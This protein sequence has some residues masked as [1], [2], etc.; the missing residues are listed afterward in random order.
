M[1]SQSGLCEFRVVVCLNALDPHLP[2]CSANGISGFAVRGPRSEASQSAAVRTAL[3]ADLAAL[4]DAV[5]HLR[6]PSNPAAGYIYAA[7]LSGAQ[8]NFCSAPF[9][10]DVPL[11]GRSR[12]SVTIITRSTDN[13]PLNPFQDLS[14]LK[15]T[16]KSP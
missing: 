1:P 14:R 7:P 15:L 16:C 8:Q 5:Q 3:T 4:Q 13:T 9:A 12:R 11:A 2:T 10:I 6:D